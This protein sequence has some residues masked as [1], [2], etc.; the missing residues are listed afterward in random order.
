MILVYKDELLLKICLKE[1]HKQWQ[2]ERELLKL[3]E[4]YKRYIDILCKS[5]FIRFENSPL[6]FIQGRPLK[7]N[8]EKLGII[9]L[10]V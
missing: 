4:N 8:N 7:F 3:I 5:I 9:L 2:R 10:Y 1:N 6:Q